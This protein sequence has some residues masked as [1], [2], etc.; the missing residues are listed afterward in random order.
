MVTF[1]FK[2][3]LFFLLEFALSMASAQSPAVD[4]LLRSEQQRFNAM[5]AR[6]TAAL[7]PLLGDDLVYIHSNAVKEDKKEH[8]AAVGKGKI[9]YQEMKRESVSARIY[10]KTGLVYG[11]LKAKGRYND[12]PFDI[13]LLYTAVYRR[14]KGVWQLVHWQSTRIP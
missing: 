8:L 14:H 3:A 6:D 4:R 1:R 11:T 12:N 2:I 5:T 10:G 7:R 9:V 13:G